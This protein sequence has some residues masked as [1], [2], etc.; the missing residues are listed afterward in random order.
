MYE[1]E[2]ADERN[3][4]WEMGDDGVVAVNGHVACGVSR[5][6]SGKQRHIH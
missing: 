3:G 2:K 5:Q 4:L 1:G 6:R